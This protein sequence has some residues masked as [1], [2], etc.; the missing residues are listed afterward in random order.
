MPYIYFSPIFVKDS[1]TKEVIRSYFEKSAK[2]FMEEVEFQLKDF[3]KE[4]AIPLGRYMYKL[5]FAPSS[6]KRG[7]SKA[8]RLIVAFI[9]VDNV[10]IPVKIYKKSNYSNITKGELSKILDEILLRGY[11]SL[12]Q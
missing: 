11:M 5:R 3:K 2:K 6:F 10:L 8:Y 4:L 12:N 7:K 1:D 9:E